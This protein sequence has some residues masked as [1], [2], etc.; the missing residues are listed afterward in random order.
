MKQY[1][2]KTGQSGVVAYQLGPDWIKVKFRSGEVYKYSYKRPGIKHVEQMK[3]RAEA[4]KGLS[5]YISQHVHDD[6]D[7]KL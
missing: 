3:L 2:D 7:D 6:Y 5:T 4:G 1:K